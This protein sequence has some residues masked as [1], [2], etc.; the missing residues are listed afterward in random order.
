MD[1]DYALDVSIEAGGSSSEIPCYHVG[2]LAL[3]SFAYVGLLDL[4][5]SVPSCPD[6]YLERLG[7]IVQLF[8]IG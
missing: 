7:N 4:A 5:E 6:L 8:L 2:H 3:A 1:A